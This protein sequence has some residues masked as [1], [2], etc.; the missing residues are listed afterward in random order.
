MVLKTECNEGCGEQGGRS[1]TSSSISRHPRL[2]YYNSISNLVSN[3]NKN[4]ELN[5]VSF[6]FSNGINESSN[7]F[8]T[9]FSPYSFISTY[10]NQ[11]LDSPSF[12]F[13]SDIISSPIGNYLGY[14]FEEPK[15]NVSDASRPQ[16]SPTSISRNKMEEGIKSEVLDWND[17]SQPSQIDFPMQISK[18]EPQ[19]ELVQ[20]PHKDCNLDPIQDPKK[21]S[22]FEDGYNWRKYGQK[23][24]K[25]SQKPRSYFKCSYPNCQTKKKVEKDLNGYITKIIY[26]GKHNHSMP[27][28]KKNFSFNSFQNT[29]IFDYSI[30]KNRFE[31]FSP[32]SLASFKEPEYDRDSTFSISGNDSSEKEPNAKRWKIDEAECETISYA[33]G[34]KTVQEPR[35][36]I[37]TKSEIDILDDG[38]KWRKYGQKVVKGNP[39]PRS[40]YKC[41]NTGCPVRKLVERAS[42]D[43][44]SVITTYEG[45][46][47][48][49][50]PS[51]GGG[52]YATNQQPKS[53]SITKTGNNSMPETSLPLTN[54]S[55]NVHGKRGLSNENGQA[56]IDQKLED[57]G[58]MG[59]SYLNQDNWARDNLLAK[60]KEEPESEFIYNSF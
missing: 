12:L 14:D 45:K 49:G 57:F 28:N 18:I 8:L 54:Y 13:N 46:H 24:V 36:V 2:S 50:V 22:R 25:G 32:N 42:H 40:Y 19:P 47:N 7:Q 38:Y 29:A 59:S 43:L 21:Q 35:V 55:Y 41:T 20:S 33:A 37:E 23:Q 15:T 51:R 27:Q 9:P 11:F 3:D 56:Y 44:R 1:N 48:H 58:F 39:N 17:K 16:T 60:T 4:E 6:D 26:K 31:P 10:P 53:Y 5:S 34:S 30:D 52:S